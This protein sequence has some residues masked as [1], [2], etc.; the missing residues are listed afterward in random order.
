VQPC[1]S[2][3]LKASPDKTGSP[4]SE[5]LE[6]GTA[7]IT[8]VPG[9][10]LEA[11]YK[12]GDRYLLFTTENIPYEEALHILLLDQRLRRLDDVELSH[13]FAGGILADLQPAG[14][15]QVRF[16]FFGADLW[17]LTVLSVPRRL[18]A[19]ESPVGIKARLRRLL[20]PRYL[21][22]ERLS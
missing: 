2:F 21:V 10:I 17:E 18:K 14:E 8:R 7:T 9:I 11:Q 15:T 3:A 4:Q 6:D 12:C 13:P 16:S 22:L 5:L 20:T 1:Q 19:R